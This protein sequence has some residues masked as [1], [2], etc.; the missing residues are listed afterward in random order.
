SNQTDT[1]LYKKYNQEITGT[2]EINKIDSLTKTKTPACKEATLNGSIFQIYNDKLQLLKTLTIT[3]NNNLI[4]DNLSFGTYII[5]EIKAGTGYL[6]NNQP[7]TITIDNNNL[8]PLVTIENKVIEKDITIEKY[9]GTTDNWLVEPN[10][11]FSIYDQDEVLVKEVTTSD[12]GKVSFTLMYGT[13]IVKQKNSLPNYQKVADFTITVS[14]QTDTLLYKKY[15]Q[16][17]TGTIE[18]N[19]IDSLTKTK[20][21][22]CKEATLNGSI[23]QIYN[24]KL[25]LLKTLTITNNNNL[26]LDNLSFGTYIIKEIKAGTG[27]LLNNQ[28]I[29][30]TIDNNNLHPLVTIENKVIEKDITIEKYYGTTDNWLVEPNITFSIYDQDE[31]LVKEVTTSDTGKV[32]FTL[33][34]GTYIVKQ[35]NSLPNYQKVADFTITVS[36]QTDTLLYKKYNQEITGTIEINKIDYATNLPI[37]NNPALFKIF[38]LTT[39]NWLEKIYSTDNN[40]HLVINNLSVG[41]Y[42]IIEVKSPLEYY[43]NNEEYLITIDL[44]HLLINLEIKNERIIYIPNTNT[45]MKIIAKVD[46]YFDK[47]K[48]DYIN[49]SNCTNM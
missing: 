31:V 5:K 38:D 30:I 9:Y 32:S 22:A 14:N 21:P 20:T 25:Q 2:I 45:T 43:I 19:K 42:K 28:P 26:I 40:G 49:S 6:L 37:T 3:N 47:K 11:T 12:T 13:Y 24:D 10:I 17:I 29:T 27:Y 36:N 8:H 34:Y 44:N 46:C 39:N 4:L 48:M 18:I 33:M 41:K 1:L 15:N 7:I 23:F 16:E 35:K